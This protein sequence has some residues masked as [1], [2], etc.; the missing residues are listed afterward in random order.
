VLLLATVQINKCL[1]GGIYK[2]GTQNKK[3]GVHYH[4]SVNGVH[5]EYY[6]KNCGGTGSSYVELKITFIF[7]CVANAEPGVSKTVRYGF[8]F[9]L[10]HFKLPKM[11]RWLARI[12]SS[13]A[14]FLWS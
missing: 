2:L 5:R 10:L 6:T 11:A 7:N 12:S 13:S 14:G 1:Y 4:K 9:L 3:D 8:I